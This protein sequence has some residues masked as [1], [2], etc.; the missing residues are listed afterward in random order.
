MRRVRIGDAGPDAFLWQPELQLLK[1][2]LAA[3][4]G[5]RRARMVS[6]VGEVGIGKSRLV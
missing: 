5:E 6:I 1:D 3:V 4:A 2:L